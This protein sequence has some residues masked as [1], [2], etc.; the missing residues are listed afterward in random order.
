MRFRRSGRSSGEPSGLLANAGAMMAS[1]LLI[2]LL[3]WAGTIFIVRTLS[4]ADFGRFTLVL[5]LLGIMSIVTDMGIGRIAVSGLLDEGPGRPRFAGSYILLRAVMGVAGYLLALGFVVVAGYDGEVV[6]ATAVGGVVILLATPGNA[7]QTVFEARRVQGRVA[8]VLALSRVVQ[9]AVT[10]AV[11]LAGGSLVALL[12][13][14]VLAE[15]LALAALAPMAH[16]LTRFTYRPDLRRWRALLIEAAPLS[17]GAAL[18]TV[19]YRVDSIMLSWLDDFEAVAVYGVAYKFVELAHFLP[20]A[21]GAA[22]LPLLVTAWPD[23]LARM[24]YTV[25]R[26]FTIAMVV[27]I[28][29]VVPFLLFAGP[30]IGLLYGDAYAAGATAAR[31]V[32]LSECLA[33]GTQLALV[34]LV[35]AGRQRLYPVIAGLGLLLNVG[36]NLVLIP[37][38]SYT[39]AAAATLITDVLV[40]VAM[41]AE[42]RRTPGLR[43][44]PRPPLARGLLA[45][46]LAAAAGLA[47]S[48]A[49][50]W[51][52]ALLVTLAVYV[53]AVL[54][55]RA[56]GPHGVLGLRHDT[57]PADAVHP[58]SDTVDDD[59]HP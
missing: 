21:L 52:V 53:G 3:G 45:G 48:S 17:V 1:R 37:A 32:V 19:Y 35:A 26:G 6:A 58:S 40:L 18:A 42:L 11:A 4:I 36:L 46:L 33:F 56:A 15:L 43:P 41:L 49:L 14:T 2:A 34:P 10:A 55:L 57:D 23:D 47:A 5:G 7:Y 8:V 59:R 50:V 31:V 29:I 13:P 24:R 39:G 54:L 20:T 28:G 25:W 44:V 16:R 12:L 38:Y 9:F 22:L 27:G 30:L 51:P